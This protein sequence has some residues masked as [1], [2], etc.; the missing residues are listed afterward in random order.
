ML[1]VEQREQLLLL[2]GAMDRD[3]VSAHFPFKLLQKMNG[4]VL[5]DLSGLTLV[6]TAGLAWLL[7]QVS[8]AK[9]QGLTIR[10]LNAPEQL[11]SLAALSDVVSLLPLVDGDAG[12]ANPTN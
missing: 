2:S 1:K 11:K 5:F 4:D 8:S 10:M 9:Q 12:Y 7:H 6:D 3:T